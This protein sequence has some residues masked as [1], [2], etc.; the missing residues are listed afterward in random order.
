LFTF[1]DSLDNN[2]RLQSSRKRDRISTIEML[3]TFILDMWFRVLIKTVPGHS[4]T[5]LLPLHWRRPIFL[6]P[7]SGHSTSYLALTAAF[8]AKNATEAPQQ[9]TM[10]M[11][12]QIRILQNL[13]LRSR[14]NKERLPN[15]IAL[16]KST[17]K[18]H[19]GEIV[20]DVSLDLQHDRSARQPDNEVS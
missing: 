13:H 20:D 1:K 14:S 19:L 9:I 18:K 16:L 5:L 7:S 6:G 11:A 15:E 4:G 3:M 2:R 17:C 12:F 8:I 10:H